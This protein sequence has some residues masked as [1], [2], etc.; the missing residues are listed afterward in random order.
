MDSS[1]FDKIA[2]LDLYEI[3]DVS[4]DADK[5]EI[6]K[7]YKQLVKVLHPDK[8]TGDSEAFQ[9]VNLAFIILKSSKTRKIYNQR[10]KEYLESGSNHL[11]LRKN[12]VSNKNK[13]NLNKEESTKL[14]YKLEEQLNK[15]HGFDKNDINKITSGKM[16]S[17]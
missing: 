8:K 9:Y 16:K 1:D 17:D 13:N 6:K 10:R 14:F 15:K 4:K 11:D 5:K 2:E 3:L 7:N 12:F